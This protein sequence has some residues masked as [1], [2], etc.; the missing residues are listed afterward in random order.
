MMPGQFMLPAVMQGARET[1]VRSAP[2]S[3]APVAASS[4]SRSLPLAPDAS[5]E[6]SCKASGWSMGSDC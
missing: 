2:I 6:T 4:T 1:L 5:R 3:P